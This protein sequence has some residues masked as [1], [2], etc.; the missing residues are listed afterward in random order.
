MKRPVLSFEQHI[1][2]K[3]HN[4][5][6]IRSKNSVVA[7]PSVPTP[8][9]KAD[10]PKYIE[11]STELSAPSV[12]PPA[13][14]ETNIV[15]GNDWTLVVGTKHK[16]AILADYEAT[17]KTSNN[18]VVTKLKGKRYS[19]NDI[20]VSKRMRLSIDKCYWVRELTIYNVIMTF[21]KEY[22]SSFDKQDLL[23][24]ALVNRDFSVMIPNVICWLKLNF[25]P[26]REPRYD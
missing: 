10:R 14:L 7:K 18:H 24:L 17:Y 22:S 11:L 13:R 1:S 6:V 25:H 2:N 3:L 4:P 12:N 21:L 16:D 15:T 23:Q 26:L 9:L 5:L 19:D 8:S 20:H